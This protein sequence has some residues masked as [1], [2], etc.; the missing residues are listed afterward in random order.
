[1]LTNIKGIEVNNVFN[2][3]KATAETNGETREGILYIRD[4]NNVVGVANTPLTSKQIT[5]I[6]KHSYFSLN[7][8][9]FGEAK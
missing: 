8:Q 2:V 3:S 4:I 7:D 6:L 5:S 1:M 9:V